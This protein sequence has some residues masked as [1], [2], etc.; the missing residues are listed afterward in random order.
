[1]VALS[2]IL[3]FSEHQPGGNDADFPLLHIHVVPSA[4][5]Q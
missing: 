2:R 1:M 4:A 5:F 3:A